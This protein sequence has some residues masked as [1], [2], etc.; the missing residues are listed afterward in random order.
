MVSDFEYFSKSTKL[1]EKQINFL[2]N[3]KNPF[4]ILIE[5]EKIT[6]NNLLKNIEKLDNSEI[7]QKIA[8]RVAHNFMHKKLIRLN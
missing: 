8:F 5:K 7:Y 1:T 3:Y 4:T 6:D 2:K